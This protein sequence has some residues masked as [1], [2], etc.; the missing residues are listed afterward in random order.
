MKD[1]EMKVIVWFSTKCAVEI[2]FQTNGYYTAHERKY[3]VKRK[4]NDTSEP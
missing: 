1:K 2:C 4:V 3:R